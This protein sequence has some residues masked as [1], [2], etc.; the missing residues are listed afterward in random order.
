MNKKASFDMI[1]NLFRLLFTIVVFVS[2][3]FLTRAF[4]QQKIDIFE[5]ES[6]LL[7]HRIVL[8]NDINYIDMDTGRTYTG[9]IDLQKFAS[10]DFE[11]NILN[12]IYYGKINSEAS[13]KITL[14]YNDEG[15]AVEVEKFYNKELYNEK[16]VLIE[17]KLIGAGAA[18]KLDTS[19]Y[20]LVKDNNNLKE[21]VLNIDAI[22][23]NQ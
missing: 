11:K 4:I 1:V 23:P 14:K 16:K 22:L 8:S 13:A 17:A 15:K 20:V 6:K 3:V 5:A 18:R 10:E 21:G 19:F 9:I 12:S 7:A 2:I